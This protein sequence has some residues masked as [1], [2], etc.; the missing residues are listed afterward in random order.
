LILWNANPT[1]SPVLLFL[2]F[3]P[4]SCPQKTFRIC[5]AQPA[6]PIPSDFSLCP[7][8]YSQPRHLRKLPKMIMARP[9][10][11]SFGSVCHRIPS[12]VHN[13]IVPVTSISTA[14]RVVLGGGGPRPG[15]R[16]GLTVLAELCLSISNLLKRGENPCGPCCDGWGVEDGGGT[17]GVDEEYMV[18]RLRGPESSL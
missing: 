18:V 15:L 16:R 14:A 9:R 10:S 11:F 3:H 7:S 13:N 1:V 6:S 4:S 12:P 5:M 17:D 8:L 2:H